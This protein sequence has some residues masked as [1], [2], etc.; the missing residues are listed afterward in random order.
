MRRA[1][2]FLS[3]IVTGAF[4][5]TMTL[6]LVQRRLEVGA[7]STF[8]ELGTLSRFDALTLRLRPNPPTPKHSHTRARAHAR[9]CYGDGDSVSTVSPHRVALVFT[10]QFFRF[11]IMLTCAHFG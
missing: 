8:L 1:K 4:A 7:L 10:F 3:K 2:A 6:R 5:Q 11:K 9:F